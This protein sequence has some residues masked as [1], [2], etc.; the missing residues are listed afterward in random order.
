MPS[1]LIKSDREDINNVTKYCLFQINAVISW[2][3]EKQ[4]LG[5]HIDK[6]GCKKKLIVQIFHNIT[7]FTVFF[8][9]IFLS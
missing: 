2:N 5:F 6:N 1:K 3:H 4:Y 7:A 9:K 8:I